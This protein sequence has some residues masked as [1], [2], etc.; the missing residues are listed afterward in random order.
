MGELPARESTPTTRFFEQHCGVHASMIPNLVSVGIPDRNPATRN[1]PAHLKAHHSGGRTLQIFPLSFGWPASSGD[2]RAGQ[3]DETPQGHRIGSPARSRSPSARRVRR[4]GREPLRT[5]CLQ[6]GCRQ[7]SPP[8]AFPNR[9]PLLLGVI[10][11]RV[12]LLAGTWTPATSGSA[13]SGCHW[14]HNSAS[15]TPR[16]GPRGWQ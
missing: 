14:S 10:A 3:D 9:R 11:R 6:R 5:R 2:R 8:A 13:G 1:A 15:D 16:S 4:P 12:G 7:R